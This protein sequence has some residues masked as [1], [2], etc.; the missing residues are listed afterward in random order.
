M[1]VKTFGTK[2]LK[3]NDISTI[4]SEFVS[5]ARLAAGAGASASSIWHILQKE[6]SPSQSFD[7]HQKC[8]DKI[9]EGIDDVKPSWI[10][11]KE[12]R[13]RTNIFKSMTAKGFSKYEDFYQWSVGS[14]SRDDFWMESTKNIKIDWE[15]E[16]SSA[17]NL[18]DG[19]AA[20]VN[21]F[22]E[23][24]L[25]ISDS[26]FNKRDPLEPA[27]VYA[28]ESDSRNL[29]EMSFKTL[30]VL[31]NQIAN[32]ITHKLGLKIGDA[33]GICMP[34]TPESVV[35]YL[36]IVKAGCVVISIADSFSPD[37]IATRCRLSN[38]K[39][40]FTQDVIFRG[41]KFLPLFERALEADS[42]LQQSGKDNSCSM[43]IV[44]LPGML[45]AKAY[46]HAS[47]DANGSTWTDTDR[48]GKQVPLHDSILTLLRQDH[49][50]SWYDLLHLCSEQYKSKKRGAMD[51][52]NILFS[53]G[54]TGEPKAIVWS[55]STP[56]KS[57][58]DG[59][60]HQDIKVG[61][62]VAWPT[63]IG[64]M[65]GPWL[66]FQLING[67]TVGLFN[68]IPS[69]KSFCEFIDEAEITM[70]GVVPSLV[71]SW[72]A[73]N[74]TENC[75]WSKIRRFSSTGEASDPAT[76]LWLMSRVQ[77]YAPVIEYCG[78]TE[79]GGSF[80][81]STLMDEN[82][83]AMFSTPVLGSKFLLHGSEGFIKGGSF[84]TDIDGSNSG[85]LVLIPPAVGMSTVLLNRDHYEEYYKGMPSSP[86]GE[87]L[88]RHGDEIEYVRSSDHLSKKNEDLRT[89]YYR[90]L[91]RSD[92]TMNIGGIKIGSVEIEYACNLVDNVLETAA[93]GVSETKGGPSNLVI[94]VVLKNEEKSTKEKGIN[95]ESLQ[96]A[97]QTSI[98][99][100]LNPLFG[101]SDVVITDYLPRTTS[102]KVMRRVLRDQYVAAM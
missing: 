14:K 50:M 3:S 21:Y 2:I 80:L 73:S 10:P 65:M 42:I 46:P 70:L 78:G 26:C 76:A 39:A 47:K 4:A 66:V 30:D 5:R 52:C 60:Y 69:T 28:V 94:Y 1:S 23:G 72:R 51:P 41:E 25:N 86:D 90:A 55:H 32:G 45:H 34:M 92:D 22:P 68:G 57:A 59:Y 48:D 33:V 88:R 87:V 35:I 77:G 93:I 37:E 84:E 53:S 36:G 97:M 43:N 75:D 67:A 15:T 81:S 17:F 56:I 91:G 31:S 89:P 62:R 24:R 58:I 95:K 61:D 99:T 8:Y 44:V 83:P 38:A 19:G 6:L 101:I 49:D 64:W 9:Y 7:V 54:T 20:H 12:D 98:K 16:P 74:A 102:N 18:T 40:I 27:L 29:R 11:S 100:K 85:E 71:K 63:N 82:V 79:I 96:A 13:E